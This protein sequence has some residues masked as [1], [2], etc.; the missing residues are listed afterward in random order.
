MRNLPVR[1]S[2]ELKENTTI[3]KLETRMTHLK[4][5][6]KGS[7]AYMLLKIDAVVIFPCRERKNPVMNSPRRTTHPTV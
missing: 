6:E 7:T 5:I 2:F 4:N 3:K 1:S